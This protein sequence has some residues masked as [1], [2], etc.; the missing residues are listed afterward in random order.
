MIQIEVVVPKGSPNKV[1]GDL[2]EQISGELLK[3]QG[4]EVTDEV[5]VTGNE[6]DLLCRHK[7]NR[8]QIYVECKAHRDPLSA[9]ILTN[10]LGT[11]V[12]KKLQ[13]GW[14]ISTGEL[15]KEAKGFQYEWEGQATEEAQKL[16]I[17]TPE[18]LYEAFLNAGLIKPP[19][20][21]N[22]LE[23]VGDEDRIG[24]WILFISP[25]G[26]YWI[27]VILSGGVPSG[28]VVFSTRTGKLIDD[29]NLLQNLASTDSS[30]NELDFEYVFRLQESSTPTSQ[31][32]VVEVQQGDNWSDYRPARPED[33]VGRKEEQT[34]ILHFLERVRR[35]ETLTRIFA[36]TGDSGMGKSSLIAKLRARTRNIRYR[37][38]IFIYAVDVR[39]AKDSSY[40]YSALLAG[41]VEAASHGFGTGDPA[42]IKIGSPK[43]PLSSDSIERFLNSLEKKS[44]V[45]CVIFD[46]F[47]EL[48]SKTELFGVFEVA[49]RLL[50]STIAAQTCFVVGFAWKTDSTVQQEH[51]AYYL[52]HRLAD[53]RLEIKL[54]RFTHAE[55]SS[56][57][58]V[59]EREIGSKLRS[60]LRR[61]L[62]ENS[63]G[64]PWLLKKLS[65]HVYEQIQDGVSQTE[66]MSKTLEI[67]SLFNRDLQQLSNAERSTLNLIARTAPA[68]WYEVLESSDQESL[69]SLQQKRLII[70]S[71]D[72]I[73]LYWD[74][75]REYVLTN[76]IPSIPVTY[77]PSSPSLRTLLSIAQQLDASVP[78]T[79]AELAQMMNLKEKTLGNIA[80]DLIM[81]GVA[82]G[83]QSQIKLSKE[84][85][86]SDPKEVL[87]ALRR[88][89]KNHALTLS[90]K[91]YEKFVSVENIIEILQEINPAAQH[92]QRTWKIYGERMG[93]WLSATG[94]LTP[95][96]GGWRIEDRGE[97]SISA[98]DIHVRHYFSRHPQR[99][100]ENT[101]FIGD[102]SP[103]KAVFTLEWLLS[104]PAI[105]WSQIEAAGHRNGARTL[106][107]LR[108]IRNH[109]G[110]YITSRTAKDETISPTKLVWEAAKKEPVV[111]L[112]MNYLAQNPLASGEEIGRL[113]ADDYERDWTPASEYRIG[114]SLLQW[115]TWLIRGIRDGIVPKPPGRKPKICEGNGAQLKLKI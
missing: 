9:N 85:I 46:Q 28:T 29:Q 83:S 88:V 19:P 77:L 104:Q 26:R 13:E 40:I 35:E 101:L 39:A 33:F 86:N 57:I 64:Y 75:F 63:Q 38:K 54:R 50:L 90:L 69:R 18:R 59:F 53:H 27:V 60:A 20:Y 94:Y 66:I 111:E 2:L 55:A 44:Q 65:I 114:S 72:R 12:A 43:S 82:E 73:N 80:R 42:S 70:R 67:E 99:Y 8:K 22:V 6:L 108:L 21:E 97:D 25:Y 37:R 95:A 41:L 11:V 17:Y 109:G 115:A 24:D 79:H 76:M 34:R 113:V 74:I 3:T 112:V 58:T 23:I 96:P 71:G 14:L 102:T 105:T 89:L 98:T 107:N 78:H 92:Q 84:M 4:Y 106:L 15:G 31:T 7:V 62:S 30:L 51:P 87:R 100:R 68:D 81:F 56:A 48:F 1:K 91:R 49:Q 61:Q 47:E 5:R 110:K 10:L 45:V 32:K 103:Y 36:V 52:W 93:Q 16:S